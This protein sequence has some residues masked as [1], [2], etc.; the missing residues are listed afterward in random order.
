MEDDKPDALSLLL[1][2]YEKLSN[3]NVDN[4]KT[5]EVMINIIDAICDIDK[6][7]AHE[8]Y[9]QQY[10]RMNKPNTN[11]KYGFDIQFL[12]TDVLKKIHKTKP[13]DPTH[14]VIAGASF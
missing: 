13:P 11:S 1:A 6:N 4:L 2:Q 7:K 9:W 10:E 5:Q 8:L 14:T 3:H 12:I